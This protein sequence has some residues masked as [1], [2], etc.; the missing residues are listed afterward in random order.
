MFCPPGNY[1]ETLRIY[2][3]TFSFHIFLFMKKTL[4]LSSAFL[5][6]HLLSPVVG[7]A[8]QA[9]PNGQFENWTT[10]NGGDAP[11]QWQTTDD[12]LSLSIPKFSTTG[13]VIKSSD[14]HAGSFAA[15]LTN[16]NIANLGEAPGF[17]SLGNSLGN[18]NRV[19]SLE[20]LG[21]LPYTSR[22]A[23]F[24]FYY[25]FA[26]TITQ[27][28]DRPKAAIRLTRTVGGVRTVVAY[29]RQ[30]L[31]LPTT[32]YTLADIPL[33]YRQGYAPDSI[34]I[35]F[36]SGD[37]EENNF[38]PGNTLYLDDLALTG[39]VTATRDPQLQAALSVYPNPSSTGL[40][41]ITA[42]REA[43]LLAGPLT[44]TDAVG[45]VVLHLPAAPASTDTRSVDLRQQPA[46]LYSLRLDT[47]RGPLMYQLQVR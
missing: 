29:G 23:R 17:L 5:A 25:K 8:Q 20:N 13:T 9:V 44:V 2:I 40:F 7:R 35:T 11:V 18:L 26:G 14:M 42:A 16:V 12:V 4:L 22:A 24:Q 1:W 30:Y 32:G 28:S 34:H 45:R 27:A 6:A 39:T 19:D 41:A 47:P 38:N 36:G 15:K 43:E 37:Y 31:T 3:R 21:G 33:T 10:R 46:G